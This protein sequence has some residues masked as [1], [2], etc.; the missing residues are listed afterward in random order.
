MD[1][2]A[3]RATLS[4][5]GPPDRLGHA[6]AALWW[7]ARGD[8]DKAH[9]EAQKDAGPMGCAVHA[10]LHRVEGDLS[11]AGYWYNRAGR[12]PVTDPLVVEWESLARELLAGR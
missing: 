2:Q 12:S 11:N 9:T 10:Y 6:L 7:D 4:Q 8:W 5:A 1:V 3:L